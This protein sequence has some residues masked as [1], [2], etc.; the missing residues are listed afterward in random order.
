MLVTITSH[1]FTSFPSRYL[2]Q[3]GQLDRKIHHFANNVLVINV[4]NMYLIFCHDTD[5]KWKCLFL[6]IFIKLEHNLIYNNKYNVGLTHMEQ[7]YEAADKPICS[8]GFQPHVQNSWDVF[9]EGK[10]QLNIKLIDN[11][12]IELFKKYKLAPEK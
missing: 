12:M 3:G 6:T 11:E 8:L 4:S 5:M 10:N 9:I 7:R 2:Q 1:I